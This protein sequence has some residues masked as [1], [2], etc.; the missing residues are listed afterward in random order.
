MK[1]K[2]IWRVAGAL[3]APVI[4]WCLVVAAVMEPLRFWIRGSDLYDEAAMREWIEE[5][6]VARE[7]LPE[8]TQNYI[9]LTDAVLDLAEQKLKVARS[10]EELDRDREAGHQ[11]DI[12]S[13]HRRTEL[14]EKQKDLED[15]LGNALI[16]AANKRG[17]IAT[18]LKALASPPTKMFPGQMP[19]FPLIY[20]IEIALD[21]TSSE[22][23]LVRERSKALP[24]PGQETSESSS[25]RAVRDL[26]KPIYW[27]SD[28][29]RLPAGQGDPAQEHNLSSRAFGPRARVT[30]QYQ[31]HTFSSQQQ[32]S[33]RKKQRANVLILLIAA[34]TGLTLGWLYF[35]QKRERDR[36]RQRMQAQQ[37]LD[38]TERLRL[39]EEVRRQEAEGRQQETERKLLEQ[40]V[41][42]QAAESQALELKSQLYASI[43]I[44]A[45]SY[46]HNIKNLLV[47][48]NDL[49]ER[50]L[51][52]DGMAP[53]Q[54]QMLHEVR[55]TLGTVTERLQQILRT[56]RRDPA[57]SEIEFLDLNQVAKGIFA[58]WAELARE[59]WKLT[60]DLLT[61]P[62]S[63]PIQGDASHLQQALENLIFNARDAT[64]EMRNRLRE[65]AR[66]QGTPGSREQRD[67]I[68]SAA[69]WRGE[70]RMRVFRLE[71]HAALEVS[72]NGIGMKPEAL[73]RCRETHFST[74][75]DNALYQGMNTG[76]GLGLSFVDVVLKH[77]RAELR[78][79]STLHEG[80]TMRMIFPLSGQASPRDPS[81][82]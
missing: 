21:F 77:H 50:C 61:A 23:V 3:A 34:A 76:M 53:A 30:M 33:Q 62:E 36:Q 49:L 44:M 80:T 39:Q 22:S 43:G 57:R 27:D 38:A 4:L 37:Q 73:E 5:T 60:L 56:V 20:R 19:L 25:L 41:A 74:K 69:A 71:D 2:R 59:K 67:A 11:E 10:L 63:L 28:L 70:V 68:I 54:S 32:E 7:T 40:R 15:R 24:E 42:T 82:R 81:Q 64:F 48:P 12:D 17:V 65:E 14:R 31:L 35:V 72:D 79:E 46:A 55:E 9:K 6:R 1:A 52:A 18:N 16:H 8:M 66:R 58:T 26:K 75:R 78:I 29:P 13:Q 45:G 47:R 51:Q